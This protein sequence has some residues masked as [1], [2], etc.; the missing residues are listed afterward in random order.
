MRYIFT[1]YSMKGEIKMNVKKRMSHA[2]LALMLMLGSVIYTMPVWA[3]ATGGSAWNPVSSPPAVNT[4]SGVTYG[5][6]IYVAVG[7]SGTIL[8]SVNGTDNWQIYNSGAADLNGVACGV[9]GSGGSLFAAVGNGG[10]ILT[11]SDGT[12]WNIQSP[13]TTTEAV[14]GITYGGGQ[15]VAVGNSGT[16][17]TSADGTTWTSITNS[18]T[19]YTANTLYGITSGPDGYGGTI[20]IAVGSGGTILTSNDGET[21]SDYSNSSVSTDDLLGVACGLDGNGDCLFTAVGSNGTILTSSDGTAWTRAA[22]PVPAANLKGITYGGGQFVAVGDSGTILVSADGSAWAS[23]TSNT[24]D[25]LWKRSLCGGVQRWNDI[26]LTGRSDLDQPDGR[27]IS[28][29]CNLWKR[30]LCWGGQQW[31]NSDFTRRKNVDQP[32][33]QYL[34]FS[35]LCN[36]GQ[37]RL[38]GGGN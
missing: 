2:I 20:F 13:S 29:S 32:D 4:L 10:T 7:S 27:S 12:A 1:A 18:G 11:S 16:I 6:G 34:G 17:L 28:Q 14:Y 22:N 3:G 25:C 38:C 5:N 31:K 30:I 24:A 33:I 21:W 36:L 26:D 8:T 35:L 23:D 19:P 15:F 37:Q 9:D